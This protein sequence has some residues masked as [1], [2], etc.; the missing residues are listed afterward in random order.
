M[1]NLDPQSIAALRQI[2]CSLGADAGHPVSLVLS[3]R[4]P[5]TQ[6][7]GV[8]PNHRCGGTPPPGAA[9]KCAVTTPLI[10]AG[11]RKASVCPEAM[12][13]PSRDADTSNRGSINS[14]PWAA[15]V[16]LLPGS[17]PCRGGWEQQLPQRV[18]KCPLPR[19]TEGPLLGLLSAES[20]ASKLKQRRELAE[21]P[22]S[23]SQ[24]QGGSDLL[25]Q[26]Q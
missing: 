11:A 14:L 24:S 7:V 2:H 22:I 26:A 6:A 23:L 9:T 25:S 21:P 16:L 19:A 13:L 3:S 1:D 15:T 12:L 5:Q 18:I 8:S 10:K 4:G 17:Q 20:P